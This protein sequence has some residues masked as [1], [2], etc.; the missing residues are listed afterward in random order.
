MFYLTGANITFKGTNALN[1]SLFR[2]DKSIVLLSSVV[3]FRE[4]KVPKIK[5]DYHIYFHEQDVVNLIYE[6]Y[7]Q[8]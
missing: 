4:S 6:S 2:E 5:T 1:S 3:D 8:R 7:G